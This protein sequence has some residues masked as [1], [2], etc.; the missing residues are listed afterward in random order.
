[1]VVRT[2]VVSVV[3]IRRVEIAAVCGN[4]RGF[5]SKNETGG[6][7]LLTS[8]TVLADETSVPAEE[9][10]DRSVVVVGFV[11]AAGRACT[12]PSKQRATIASKIN[13]R[14][15]A[16][17]ARWGCGWLVGSAEYGRGFY[18]VRGVTRDARR[19]TIGEP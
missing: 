9:T 4:R 5:V 2:W 17:F 11:L 8:V 16:I 19:H 1:M 6:V 15:A 13:R 18:R 10:D 3:L 7:S 12:A 14:V